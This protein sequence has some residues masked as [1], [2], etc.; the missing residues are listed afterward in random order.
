MTEHLDEEDAKL[1][2]LARGAMGRTGGAQGAAVRDLDGRTYAAGPV[3]LDALT[4][5]ALQAAIAAALSSG[6]EGFE[7]AAVVGDLPGSAADIVTAVRDN[8]PGVLAL[9][10]VTA[11]AKLIAARADGS[12]PYVMG[13]EPY[14]PISGDA[15]EH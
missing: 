1:V 12:D 9:T 6:A 10:E 7:A 13:W 11:S 2:V 5:T 14:R 15:H 3:S 4:L 8:E